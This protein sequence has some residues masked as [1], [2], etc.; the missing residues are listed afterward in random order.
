MKVSSPARHPSRCD[1][2]AQS[3]PSLLPGRMTQCPLR[4]QAAP[5]TVLESLQDRERQKL[6][7]EDLQIPDEREFRLVRTRLIPLPN[8]EGNT[9]SATTGLHQDQFA[10]RPQILDISVG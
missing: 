3:I 9:Q 10:C 5:P 8:D 6:P 7:P 4:N 2:R 1:P